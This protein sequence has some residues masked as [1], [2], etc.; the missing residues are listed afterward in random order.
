MAADL[1]SPALSD[2]LVILGAAGIVI[3]AFARLRVSPVIGFILVGIVAGPFALGA[4]SATT[5]W[6]QAVSI[7]DPQGIAPFAESSAE[8]PASG[9]SSSSAESEPRSP[10]AC[11]SAWKP[12]TSKNCTPGPDVRS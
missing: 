7:T 1:S 10:R 3:P 8:G 6:L 5:P 12:T 4:M 9:N 2:A 11:D